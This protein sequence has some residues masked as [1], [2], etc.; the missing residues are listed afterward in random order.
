[1]LQRKTLIFSLL[2]CLP[3]LAFSQNTLTIL[4]EDVQSSDGFIAVGVYTN[5]DT[6]LK[7]EKAFAGIFTKAEEGVTRIDLP[8]LPNG[9]YA[10]CIFHDENGNKEMDTNFIGIPKEPLGFSIGKLKTFGPPS[11]DECSFEMKGDFEIRIPI[12]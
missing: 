10:V 11:F 4:V 7:N 8:D 1:M 2:M 9:E 6:F 5:K 12:N 3:F